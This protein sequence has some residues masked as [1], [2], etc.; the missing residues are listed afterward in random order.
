[1]SSNKHTE[2]LIYIKGRKEKAMES[3]MLNNAENA[4][5]DAALDC[6]EQKFGTEYTFTPEVSEFSC[7]CSGPAQSCAWH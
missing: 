1:M 6:L 7:K 3:L 4:E 2:L 5:L